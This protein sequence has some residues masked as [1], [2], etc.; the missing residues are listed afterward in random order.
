M[1]GASRARALPDEVEFVTVMSFDSLDA[2]RT[3]AGEHYEACV[4]PPAARKPRSA[5]P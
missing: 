1:W 2:V 5:L 4:V 3:F